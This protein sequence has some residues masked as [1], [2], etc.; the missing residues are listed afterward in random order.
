MFTVSTSVQPSIL[1]PVQVRVKVPVVVLVA[2][3]VRLVAFEKLMF[4]GPVHCPVPW[5]KLAF[6]V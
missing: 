3:A 1:V 4:A 6:R 5:L 2:M